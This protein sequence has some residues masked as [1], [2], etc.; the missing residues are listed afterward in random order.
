VVRTTN[1]GTA[2]G[3]TSSNLSFSP[4]VE[5]LFNAWL[6][7]RHAA[8]EEYLFDNAISTLQQIRDTHPD[9]CIA[10]ITNGRGSPL[11][12]S[13]TLEPFFDFCVSGEDET[14]FP[15]RKPQAGIYHESLR[16]Y[17]ELYPHHAARNGDNDEQQG[18]SSSSTE[19]VWCHV[20]DCLAN[21]V[22]ASAAVGAKAVW[23]CSN[24]QEEELTAAQQQWSTASQ[25]DREERARLSSAAREQVAVRIASLSELPGA[26]QGLLVG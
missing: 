19:R 18:S 2:D 15:A 20:G 12:M 21:D 22:G 4:L 16:R 6:D 14:V 26:L 23:F 5:D 17:Q 24:N 10:A 11:H 7:E 9:V 3:D 25:A 13:N 1:T 8:A